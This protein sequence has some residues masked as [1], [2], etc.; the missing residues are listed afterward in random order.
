MVG[1]IEQPVTH[2]KAPRLVIAGVSGDAGK[3]IVIKYGGKAMTA[4]RI[5]SP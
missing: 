4:R 5:I 3:T 2:I 1:S